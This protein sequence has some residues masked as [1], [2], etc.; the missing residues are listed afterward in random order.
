[1]RVC[2]W[3]IFFDK[4]ICVVRFFDIVLKLG[5]FVVCV[6]WCD[7]KIFFLVFLVFVWIFGLDRGD[8]YGFV[9]VECFFCFIWFCGLRCGY[10][11]FI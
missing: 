2:L 1:M 7:K 11:L 4:G 6:L 3:F 10:Y 8:E 5:L 9:L